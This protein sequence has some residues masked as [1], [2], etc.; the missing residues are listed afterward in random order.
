MVYAGNFA[1]A[2]G[3][4]KLLRRG[5]ATQPGETILP[6]G[7]HLVPALFTRDEKTLVANAA[8]MCGMPAPAGLTDDQNRRLALARW[9]TH[10]QNPLAARVIANRIWQGHFGEGLV[11]TP[12]DIGK[13]GTPP[14]HPELLDWMASDLVASGWRL[15][16]LHRLIVTSATWRQASTPRADALQADAGSRL[17]WRFPPRRLEAESIRDAVLSVSGS[18]DL[19]MGGPGFSAF[20]PNE[21]YVRVYMPKKSFGTED[22]RRTIYM[23]RIRMRQDGTFGAFDCPDGGQVAPKRGRSTTP[24][25]ALNLLNSP[26][27]EQQATLF[28]ERLKKEA[29]GKI[30]DQIARAFRLAFGRPPSAEEM[31][32]ATTLVQTHGLP[33][34]CR[35]LVNAN[36][37]LFLF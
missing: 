23:T 27:M 10:P 8:R 2:P 37:F 11:S 16:H 9:I 26:F 5:D 33:A 20:E 29:G 14:T 21:N 15:K 3:E 12:G 1:A 7:T 18:L 28:A 13:K 34:L 6:G 19:T 4:T 25:Q 17:L 31:T 32:D 36:E 22:W 30:E 35:A 24:L